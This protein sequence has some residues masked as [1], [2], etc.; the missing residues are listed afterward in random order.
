MQLINHKSH[1]DAFPASPF[2]THITARFNQLSEDTDVPPNIILAENTDDITGPNYAFV[3]NRGL[4]SDL[5][6]EHRPGQSEFSRP[7]EWVSHLPELQLYEALL[8]VSNEDAYWILIPDT[9]V[10]AHPDLKW[11]FTDESQGGSSDPQPF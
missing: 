6:E 10:E 9:V 3:G 1:L 11:I 7:Y 4:L 8:L 5:W 2:K